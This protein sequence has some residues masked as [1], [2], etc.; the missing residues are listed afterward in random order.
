MKWF[1]KP[2][3][4][5]W[6]LRAWERCGK[7][8]YSLPLGRDLTRKCYHILVAKFGEIY[9]NEY[10]GNVSPEFSSASLISTSIFVW[11]YKFLSTKMFTTSCAMMAT[12]AKL[13]K[14]KCFIRKYNI[15][16]N[17]I[18]IKWSGM[19][20]HILIPALGRWRWGIQELKVIF[21]C[22]VSLKLPWTT[23]DP[24]L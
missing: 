15:S 9:D 21:S 19:L 6:K 11:L 17:S 8:E 12:P 23:C 16:Y 14:P 20:A 13:S 2:I 1:V 18:R 7:P 3:G 4:K 10:T 24:I 5:I 22:M